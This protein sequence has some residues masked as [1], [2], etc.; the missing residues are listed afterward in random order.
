MR[1]SAIQTGSNVYAGA[2]KVQNRLKDTVTAPAT[3]QQQPV[4]F[5]GSGFKIG[6]GAAGALIG[7][8]VIGGPVGALVG[9][10][11]GL[12]GAQAAE[13]Q[14]ALDEEKRKNNKK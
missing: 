12:T 2:N 1:I 6:L 10:A 9:L 8:L 7:G 14:E 5:K 11:A 4:A 13:D 3:E